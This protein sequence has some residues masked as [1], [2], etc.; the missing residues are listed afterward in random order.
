VSADA[1]L[2][3]SLLPG[4]VLLIGPRGSG[5]STLGRT[6]ADLL[7]WDFTDADELLEERSGRRIAAWLPADETGF[8][9]AEAALLEELVRPAARVV[10][11]GGGVVESASARELLARQ[12]HVVALTAVPSVLVRRQEGSGRPPLTDLPLEDEVAAILERRGPWYE[13]AARGRRVDTSGSRNASLARLLV[14]LDG[15]QGGG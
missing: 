11:L 2:A 7:G 4:P 3:E 8:R 14:R 6:L 1:R 15:P 10:A 5:K 12:D 13:E 9:A